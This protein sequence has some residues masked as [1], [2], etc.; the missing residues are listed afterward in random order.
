MGLGR[1]ADREVRSTGCRF[2]CQPCG[3]CPSRRACGQTVRT[4]GAL[5]P[6]DP[7]S[8]IY[9]YGKGREDCREALD[10]E[11]CQRI[12]LCHGATDP[13]YF[14]DSRRPAHTDSHKKGTLRCPSEE[15]TLGACRSSLLTSTWHTKDRAPHHPEL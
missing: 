6:R 7:G 5:R 15:D 8:G 3:Q 10:W 14:S 9:R 1:S 12:G 11:P 2:I 4:F 13:G